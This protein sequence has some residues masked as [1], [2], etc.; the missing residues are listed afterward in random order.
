MGTQDVA[1]VTF[2][3]INPSMIANNKGAEIVDGK[4]KT[5]FTVI[6]MAKK[7]QALQFQYS[8]TVS[9]LFDHVS[10]VNYEQLVNLGLTYSG[11]TYHTENVPGVQAVLFGGKVR[12]VVQDN[13][14]RDWVIEIDDGF[15]GEVPVFFMTQ[16]DTTDNYRLLL[17]DSHS[18]E[19]GSYLIGQGA[20]TPSPIVSV[21]LSKGE[22]LPAQMAYSRYL[23]YVSMCYDL[24]RLNQHTVEN[25]PSG[26]TEHQLFE[27]KTLLPEVVNIIQREA[28]G[29]VV[30]RS[31]LFPTGLAHANEVMN[32]AGADNFVTH[33]QYHPSFEAI[34]N[35]WADELEVGLV[36]L[37]VPVSLEFYSEMNKS[38]LL[39]EKLGEGWFDDYQAKI[40]K[41]GLKDV[42]VPAI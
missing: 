11:G 25:H 18:G 38:G 42:I 22:V 1:T 21:Y 39:T 32:F 40:E 28:G 35:R 6:K 17:I 2:G 5:P 19:A 30:T 12:L 27:G 24:Y 33:F 37:G 29:N 4:T 31:I 13:R 20:N 10:G 23:T 7:G 16:V 26:L 9:T 41:M 3:T 36:Q 14:T 8:E 34:Y 15:Y